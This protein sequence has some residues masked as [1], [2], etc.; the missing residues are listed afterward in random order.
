MYDLIVIG[1]GSAGLPAGMYA[2]RYK[3]RTLVIGELLGGALTQSHCVENYPGYKSIPGTELMDLFREHALTSGAEVI[4]G[5]VT[6]ISGSFGDFT[7]TTDRGDTYKSKAL[8][9]AQGNQ[10]RKLG[11][12]GEEKFIGSGVSYCATCDG[13]FFRNREVAMVGGGDSAVTEALYLAEICARVHVLVRRDTFRAEKVWLDK[14]L[15]HPH[16]TIHYNTEVSEIQGGFGVERLILKNG[17]TLAV[18]GIFIAIGNEPDTRLFAEYNLAK[19]GEGYIQVDAAQMTS[20]PGIYAA[21]DITT[22]SNKFKQTI[23]S[24]AE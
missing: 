14:L 23:M 18:D 11:V 22:N 21:G 20:V 1:A 8:L 16:I 19:D 10:Y 15:A 24:A 17:E 6:G 3:L 13:N 4:T 2:A 7:V 12:T 5:R 9:I